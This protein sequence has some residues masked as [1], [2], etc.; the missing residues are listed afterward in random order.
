MNILDKILQKRGIKSVDQLSPE[1]KVTFEGWRKV[2]AKD[3]LTLD[4]IKEFCQLQID[5]IE[6]KWKDYN[7]DNSKKAEFI[8]YHTVYKALLQVI[9][10]PKVEREQLEAQLNQLL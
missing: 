1:E 5:I 4:D 10:S 7:L 6:G 3:E 9:S 8:P 2:L